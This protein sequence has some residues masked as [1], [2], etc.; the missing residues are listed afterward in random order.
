L[1]TNLSWLF[2]QDFLQL[3]WLEQDFLLLWWLEQLLLRLEHLMRFK[4]I[5]VPDAAAFK[6]GTT[7]TLSLSQV[8]L[9]IDLSEFSSGGLGMSDILETGS[10]SEGSGHTENEHSKL[11]FLCGLHP[12]IR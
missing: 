7:L 6:G 2:E 3:W 4:M 10:L 9:I 12:I 11:L 1:Q 8:V 5:S